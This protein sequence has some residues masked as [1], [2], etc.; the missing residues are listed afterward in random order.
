MGVTQVFAKKE[1]SVQAKNWYKD[2]Y[3]FVLVQRNILAVISVVALFC[4]AIAVFAVMRL[5]PQ[6]SVEPF[7]IQIDEKSGI[8]ER[9]DP[10]TRTELTANEAIDRY[11]VAKYVRA[12]ENYLLGAFRD[13]YNMVRVMSNPVVFQNYRQS[14]SENNPQSP[15]VVLKREGTRQVEFKSISFINGGETRDGEKIVQARL[16]F[17][18]SGPKLPGLVESH[19]IATMAF[20]YSNID[21]NESERYLNPLGFIVNNYTIEKE[22]VR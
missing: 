14:I 4:S 10:V 5:T 19:Y 3:Q 8:V 9:V 7:V 15:V 17:K 21:L 6:K 13:N 1:S 22:V 18:D 2:K 12:R 16:L 11:F 20:Q